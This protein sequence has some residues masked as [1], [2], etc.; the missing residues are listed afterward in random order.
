[1][2]RIL[3]KYDGKDYPATKIKLSYNGI[4]GHTNEINKDLVYTITFKPGCKIGKNAQVVLTAYAN[5]NG[6][7]TLATDAIKILAMQ[8]DERCIPYPNVDAVK[9]DINGN[10]Q[11]N[12]ITCQLLRRFD[13]KNDIVNLPYKNYY[14]KYCFSTAP[15]NQ[16]QYTGPI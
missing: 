3:T 13:D 6:E 16:I 1:M 12:H 11:P 2:C 5:I 10:F 8:K 14:V 15:D 9:V 4:E 7:E